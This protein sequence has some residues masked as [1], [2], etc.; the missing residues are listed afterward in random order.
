MSQKMR[1]RYPPPMPP[2]DDHRGFFRLRLALYTLLGVGCTLAWLM[3]RVEKPGGL[4]LLLAP[5]AGF[6]LLPGLL[7][8]GRAMA[9]ACALI[10]TLFLTLFLAL[11]GGPSNPCTALYFVQVVWVAIALGGNW[12]WAFAGLTTA[13]YAALFT[14]NRPLFNTAGQVIFASQSHP[15]MHMHDGF[16]VHVHSEFIRHLHLA[17]MMHAF[18]AFTLAGFLQYLLRERKAREA[19]EAQTRAQ[20]DRFATLAAMAAGA[21]HEI[22]T[23]LASIALAAAQIEKQTG[24]Q[25]AQDAALI[26]EQTARCRAV[27]DA[28]DPQSDA[29]GRTPWADLRLSLQRRFGALLVVETDGEI[30]DLGLNLLAAERIG[31]NL[32][33]NA[34]DA[35]PGQPAQLRA[36]V[37]RGQIL[38]EIRDQGPGMDDATLTRAGEPFF[39]TKEAGRGMGLGVFVSRL[40]VER[41]GGSLALARSNEGGT[42]AKVA[43][44]AAPSRD[45]GSV[46]LGKSAFTSQSMHEGQRPSIP[47]NP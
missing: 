27:L 13:A 25:T 39:T 4:F 14:W 34:L 18:A 45:R 3:L 26:R 46:T 40:L 47:G 28:M 31:A 15:V 30:P 7:Y 42:C 43:V 38:L 22:A 9:V 35:A 19:R 5:M 44:P 36:S 33:H 12:S 8:P 21:A 1:Y 6:S 23:P 11:T 10:D 24:G 16:A 20:A 32:I 29:N 2:P 41:A 37:D 17:W